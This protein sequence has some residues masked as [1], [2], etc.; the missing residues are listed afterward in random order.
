M[1][2]GSGKEKKVN[3]K[4]GGS[5]MAAP[6]PP[7]SQEPPRLTRVVQRVREVEVVTAAAAIIVA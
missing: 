6:A 1:R 2:G 3:D 5:K 4:H 7:R